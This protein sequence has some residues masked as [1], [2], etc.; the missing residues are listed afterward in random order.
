M[1]GTNGFWMNKTM[2]SSCGVHGV[3][4]T[5]A[6][7]EGYNQVVLGRTPVKGSNCQGEKKDQNFRGPNVQQ[8]LVS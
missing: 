8:G 1:P 3:A 4:E 5:G 2:Y 7:C 6:D